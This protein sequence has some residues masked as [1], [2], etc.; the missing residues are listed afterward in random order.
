MS[1]ARRAATVGLLAAVTLVLSYVEH[2][3]PMSI[4]VPGVKPGFANIGVLIT[5]YTLGG[6]YAALVSVIRV[7]LAGLL[8]ASFSGVLYSLAGAA[9]A[10]VVMLLLHRV[11]MFGAVGVSVGGAAAHIFGQLAVAACLMGGVVFGYAPWMIL[12][13]IVTGAVNGV[14]AALVVRALPT[15]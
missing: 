7:L 6:G 13:A 11:K 9:A 4:A 1:A 2:L 15:R 10:L 12:S 14:I 3:I 5:L 8:F